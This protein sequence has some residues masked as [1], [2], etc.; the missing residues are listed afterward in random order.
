MSLAVSIQFTN[1][2]KEQSSGTLAVL[3][4][5]SVLKISQLHLEGI[6]A[7]GRT[8]Q[9]HE[10]RSLVAR[11]FVDLKCDNFLACP[12]FALYE[13]RNFRRCNLRQESLY[14]LHFR[15]QGGQEK[16]LS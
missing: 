9:F 16:L 15:A 13:N 11:E 12:T 8:A 4:A 10:W 5:L 1:F 7:K 2:I 14:G 3:G 6:R